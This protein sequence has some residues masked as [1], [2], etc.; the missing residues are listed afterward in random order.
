MIFRLRSWNVLPFAFALSSV[1]PAESEPALFFETAQPFF[2]TQIQIDPAVPGENRDANF[3]VRGVLLPIAQTH[4]VGFDQELLRVAG[5]WTV[6]PNATPVTLHTMPQ[7]SYARPGAKVFTEHPLPTGPL[8]LTTGMHPGVSSDLE[9]LFSDPRAPGRPGDHGRGP[10]PADFAR[11]DGVELLAGTALLRYRSGTTE[12]AEWVDVKTTE[13]GTI[14]L[15]HFEISAHAHPLHFA[16]GS[17]RDST[18]TLPSE[19]FAVALLPE[20]RAAQFATNS[21]ATVSIHHG[22]LVATI[23]PSPT[24]QRITLAIAFTP[25][26]DGAAGQISFALPPTP[27]LPS[28][29]PERRWP[30]ATDT[31]VQHKTLDHNGL[32]L[33]RIPV[34]EGNLWR[35]RVRPADLAF[36]DADRAAVVTYD[37]DV[38]LIRGLADH[39]R[40]NVTWERFASGL[41]EPLAMTAPDRVIQVATKN[42]IVRLHDRDTNGEA[43]WYENF[44]DQLVQSQNTRSFSLDMTMA[45]DGSTFVTQGGIVDQSGIKSGGTGTVHT[46]G[47]LKIS[48]DGRSSKLFAKGAREPFIAVHPETG[49]VTGTDQ[50]GHYI[51]SSVT[52]LIREGDSFGF[53]EKEP[54]QIT[55]PL[56]WIPHDQDTSSTSQ[57]W[58]TGQGMGPWQGRLLHLSYGTGRIFVIAPDFDAPVPQAAVIPLNFKTDLPLLHARMHPAGDAVFFAGFQIWGTRTTAKWALGRLRPGTTPVATAIAA[59]STTDG[60]VLEFAEPVEPDSLKAENVTAR[61]WNYQRSSNYGSGRYTLEGKDGTNALPVGQVIASRDRKSVFIHLR[62]LPSVMQ[63]ELRHE[64]RLASGPAASGVV[65]FTVN[66]PHAFDLAAAGFDPVDLTKSVFVVTQAVE[67]VATPQLGKQLAENFGCI[68]C[69]SVDGTTEGK[70]GPTWKHLFGSRRTF[71]DGTSEIADELYLREKILDPMKKRVMTGAAEMPSYRG[72]LSEAQ[73][74]SLIFYMRSLRQRAQGETRPNVESAPPAGK[75]AEKL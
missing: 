14:F 20:S 40:S 1:C 8:L 3:V 48:P 45:P 65:Y 18:W 67:E 10:L 38:W 25:A 64:F 61:A 21:N 2:H 47:V 32:I 16:L 42:G 56:A 23:P 39:R 43:D 58:M 51:P 49:V 28:A 7:I 68:A 66:Q 41:H 5:F 29:T 57:V 74:E 44:S 53:P 31:T 60:V 37:G 12:I 19:G 15:R 24:K 55:P 13:H 26:G 73:L 52:Y 46:G 59:R 72:V 4:A 30:G 62:N 54:S 75:P 36:L 70:V 9:T 33:D 35:R 71:V 27:T 17:I 50:Q 34:P 69:H 11:F 22:E 63:V 6:P